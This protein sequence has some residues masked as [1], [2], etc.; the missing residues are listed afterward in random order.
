MGCSWT[1]Q[2]GGHGLP[3]GYLAGTAAM[4]WL[5][6]QARRSFWLF[7]LLALPGTLCHE[8]CH[9][10]IGKLLNGRP[11]H[12]TVIP[13]RE[14]HGFVLGSVALQN[15]R[16]YNAFFIGLA[17]LALLPLAYGLFLWRLGGNPGFGWPE[18]VMLYLLANLLFGSMPSWQDLR[19][20]AR[21]PIGWLLLAGVLVWGW[22]RYSREPQGTK[23]GT[24]KTTAHSDDSNRS[25]SPDRRATLRAQAASRASGVP[26]SRTSSFARV[27]AV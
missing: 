4:L 8:A 5:M 14:G 25:P 13:R 3:L 19:M 10:V 16:W 9:W 7:S 22:M 17:P 26:S 18:A 12:L 2:A 15:L 11:I 21:S 20:A 1:L 6:N 24:Q 27:R 23:S